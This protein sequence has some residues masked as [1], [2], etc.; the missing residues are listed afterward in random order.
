[1]WFRPRSTSMSALP[2]HISF[3]QHNPL[4]SQPLWKVSFRGLLIAMVA[5]THSRKEGTYHLCHLQDNHNQ[6]RG[7]DGIQIH[8]RY[9]AHIKTGYTEFAFEKE[10]FQTRARY[11][12]VLNEMKESDINEKLFCSFLANRHHRD[13]YLGKFTQEI[14]EVL[15]GFH[16][17]YSWPKSNHDHP[18]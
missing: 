2:S 8:R 7:T 10:H 13:T 17:Q 3:P 1:M 16:D 12:T 6:I 9:D 4:K 11:L 5:G 18:V 15:M 14:R